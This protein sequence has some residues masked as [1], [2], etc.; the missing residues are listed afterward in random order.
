MWQKEKQITMTKPKVFIIQKAGEHALNQ[1]FRE[2]LCFKRA[3][4]RLGIESTVYGKG[5]PNG[6]VPFETASTGYDI[7]LVLE[8][9]NLDDSVPDI[10]KSKAIK[11]FWSIDSHMNGVLDAHKAFVKKNK[12][13][14]VLNANIAHTKEYPE[15]F[16]AW[17][18]NAFDE[19]IMYPMPEIPKNVNIGFC[20]NI[21]NRGE[22]LDNLTQQVGL[23]QDIFV[24]GENMVKAERI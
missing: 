12:I 17:F 10:S 14:A 24:I 9:Y 18:P 20:G 21:Q 19:T 11:C 22:I 8:N 4:D 5:Y 6:D 2:A 7:I 16:S 23:K 3:F 13:D 1:N 15:N